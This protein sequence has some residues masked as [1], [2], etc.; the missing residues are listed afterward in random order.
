MNPAPKIPSWFS[1]RYLRDRLCLA[2]DALTHRELLKL[3]RDLGAA[4]LDW[5]WLWVEDSL[6]VLCDPETGVIIRASEE[7]LEIA[8]YRATGAG[9]FLPLFSPSTV[10]AWADVPAHRETAMALIN[11]AIG[12]A[13]RE[14]RRTFKQC[15]FCKTRLPP[16]RIRRL[17]RLNACASCAAREFGVAS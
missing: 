10:I 2:P 11:S 8:P 12:S 15:D 6:F 1:E 17:H 9:P 16:E 3:A 5:D 4:A 13:K 7:A 14:R